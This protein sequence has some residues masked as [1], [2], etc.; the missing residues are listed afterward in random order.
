MSIEN[1]VE[2]IIFLKK[3]DKIIELENLLKT[4]IGSK[5]INYKELLSFALILIRE[6]HFNES[7]LFL[8][9]AI[10]INP[11][12]IDAYINLANI[13]ILNKDYY[14]SIKFFNIA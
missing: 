6:K 9:K 8:E 5:I 14:K 13:Y 10:E 12:K 11:S 7:I 3:E 1:Q 4:I 2:Q